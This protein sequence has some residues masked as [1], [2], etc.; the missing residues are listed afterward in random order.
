MKKLSLLLSILIITSCNSPVEPNEK[1]GGYMKTGDATYDLSIGDQSAVQIWD[2]FLEAHNNQ[3]MDAI[4]AM[5]SEDIKIWGPDGNV[6]E[7][8]EAHKEFLTQW[9]ESANPKWNSYFSIPIKV[10]WENQPGTWV[11]NGHNLTLTVDGVESTSGNI[12]DAYIEDGLVKMFYVF[13]R[14]LPKPMETE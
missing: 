7:G 5:E 11:T 9:F 3:D 4:M 2:Q 6:I 12:S 13:R 10:N 8:K 1:K 14:E